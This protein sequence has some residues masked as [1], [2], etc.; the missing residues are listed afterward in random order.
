MCERAPAIKQNRVATQNGTKWGAFR[1][2][3]CRVG[4]SRSVSRAGVVGYIKRHDFDKWG[5]P[6]GLAPRAAGGCPTPDHV[7]PRSR[8]PTPHT[9]WIKPASPSLRRRLTTWASTVRVVTA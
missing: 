7:W 5:A 4:R 9:V 3:P 6:R 2:F 1:V 8:Y